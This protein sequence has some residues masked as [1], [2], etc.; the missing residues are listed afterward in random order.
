MRAVA[1]GE[2]ALTAGDAAVL[3]SESH[4]AGL[5]S[6]PPEFPDP[7]SGFWFV[8]IVPEL[9]ARDWRDV[10]PSALAASRARFGADI[11]DSRIQHWHGQGLSNRAI[12]AR[13]G[14]TL[15]TVTAHLKGSNI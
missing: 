13:L 3:L 14:V 9:T 4:R 8:P 5:D 7:E 10:E 6:G 15:T 1:D 12:A 2:T 11:L